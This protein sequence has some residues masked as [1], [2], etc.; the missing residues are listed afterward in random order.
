MTVR[1]IRRRRP[2]AT[3]RLRPFWLLLVAL[4]G[5][6]VALAYVVL[7]LPALRPRTIVV[8]GNAVVSREAILARAEIDA[9]HNMW[10]QNVKAI[11]ARVETIPYIADVEVHRRPPGTMILAVTERVPFAVLTYGSDRVLVDRTLRVLGPAQ[12][13]SRLPVLAAAFS[14]D[15]AP[16]AFVADPAI[17]A[18]RD[19]EE[20][21]A[22]ANVDASRLWHDK[23]GDLVVELRGGVRVLLG[24]ERDAQKKIPLVNPILQQV[25]RTGRGIATIDLRAPTTPVVVYRK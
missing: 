2:P 19:D 16:G 14:P 3:A 11:A 13:A 17:E 4:G 25:G 6:A 5:V 7:R 18:L 12:A 8:T 10:L 22:A 1:R 24:D 23:Y 20:A 21:L 9:Q 15:L